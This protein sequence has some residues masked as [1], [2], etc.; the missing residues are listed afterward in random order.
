MYASGLLDLAQSLAVDE[1]RSKLGGGETRLRLYGLCPVVRQK[2]DWL[3]GI[4]VAYNRDTTYVRLASGVGA[5][6]QRQVMDRA[7]PLRVRETIGANVTVV[8]RTP[9][10]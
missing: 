3:P 2:C 4:A 6:A 10:T 1:P 8:V 7:A 5:D 9:A